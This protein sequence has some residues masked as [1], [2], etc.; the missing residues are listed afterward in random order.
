MIL[1][2]ENTDATLSGV[3]LIFLWF[4]PMFIAI[5]F[6]GGFFEKGVTHIVIY[7]ASCTLLFALWGIILAYLAALC[8]IEMVKRK[9]RK[10]IRL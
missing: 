3:A 8:G 7:F 4:T 5:Y 6:A 1:I 9:D 10:R 2:R